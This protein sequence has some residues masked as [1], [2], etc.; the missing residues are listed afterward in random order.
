MRAEVSKVQ[1]YDSS[2]KVHAKNVAN[3]EAQ[4]LS[5]QVGVT[6]PANFYVVYQVVDGAGKRMSSG[7]VD[8]GVACRIEKSRTGQGLRHASQLID[9]S[10]K[11][12]GA[13]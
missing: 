4:A 1:M 6:A 13:K 5:G 11:A 10:V 7:H 9:F 8:L 2:R 12:K 3:A